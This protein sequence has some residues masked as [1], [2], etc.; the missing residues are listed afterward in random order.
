M[1]AQLKVRL[2][3]LFF[4][5]FLQSYFPVL[6]STTHPN[7]ANFDTLKPAQSIDPQ[8]RQTIGILTKLELMDAGMYAL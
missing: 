5:F 6:C 4:F 3:F 1:S 2:P 7:L 8:A